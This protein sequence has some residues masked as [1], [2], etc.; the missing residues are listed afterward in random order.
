MAILEVKSL[1]LSFG[2]LRVLQK[3][4]FAVE[5]RTITSL[6]GPNGAGKTS[7]FNVISRLLSPSAGEVWFEGRRLDGLGADEVARRGIGRMFQDPRI[8]S[9]MTVLENALAGARLR[10]SGPW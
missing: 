10:A 3:V 8:F 6:V 1:D 4:S 5:E 9:G 7:V 2:G